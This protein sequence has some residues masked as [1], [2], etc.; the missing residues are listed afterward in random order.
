MNSPPISSRS[1]SRR[2]WRACPAMPTSARSLRPHARRPRLPSPRTRLRLGPSRARCHPCHRRV[3]PTAGSPTR[4]TARLPVPPT[5]TTGSDIYLVRE[6]G[7]PRL[8]AGREGGTTRNV[9]PAFSP[10][11]TR[12]AFG[13]ASPQGRAVVVVGRRC[14]WSRHPSAASDPY[15]EVRRRIVAPGPGPA[16]CPRWSSDGTRLAY[17]DGSTVVVRGTRWFD[18]G[19]RW[20]DRPPPATRGVKDLERGRDPSDPLLVAV[21]RLDGARGLSGS[22]LRDRRREAGW[23]GRPRHPAELRPLCHRRAGHPTAGRSSSWRT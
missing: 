14:R 10:D 9:C 5:I 11:G 4:R 3:P 23:H 21:G 16:V 8:I 7:E 18:V 12:L 22:E 20:F 17:L 1:R 2:E 6:G 15:W 13:V 19:P